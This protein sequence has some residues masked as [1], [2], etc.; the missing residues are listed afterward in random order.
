MNMK[1]LD[2]YEIL[3]FCENYFTTNFEAFLGGF[4]GVFLTLM[5][6]TMA[7]MSCIQNCAE[8]EEKNDD[9]PKKIKKS[10][11][12]LK[13][14]KSVKKDDDCKTRKIVQFIEENVEK[15]EKDEKPEKSVENSEKTET[16]ETPENPDS[17]ET[18]PEP[19]FTIPDHVK[20]R[21]KQFREMLA[22]KKKLQD[23][24]R[25]LQQNRQ[26]LVRDY[27]E[28]LVRQG[29]TKVSIMSFKVFY[30]KDVPIND[31]PVV[32]FFN[33]PQN[34]VYILNLSNTSHLKEDTEKIF[35]ERIGNT[36]TKN[37]LGTFYPVP[38]GKVDS[39]EHADGL[40]KLIK[41][42]EPFE[43]GKFEEDLTKKIK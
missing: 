38:E 20:L 2:L 18:P 26:H 8:I 23:E 39:K 6:L 7:A 21:N 41:F 37:H 14:E 17:Q 4:I 34:L 30:P 11:K 1:Q 12:K 13:S 43:I 42:F 28:I 5:F 16:Q 15:L 29:I 27:L 31:K 9:K 24:N 40:K 36:F 33:K 10:V 3:E 22:E 19:V 35:K 32:M 25:A